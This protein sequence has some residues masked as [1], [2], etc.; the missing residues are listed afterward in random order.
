MKKNSKEKTARIYSEALYEAAENASKFDAVK[1]DAEFLAD[2]CV[3]NKDLIKQSSSPLLSDV[4]QREIWQQVAAKAKFNEITTKCLDVLIENHRIDILQEV[5]NDFVHLY[6]QRK[7]IA[8]V[9]VETVKNLTAKQDEMLRKVLQKKLE[10]DVVIEYVINP[11]LLGGLRI[12]S[13]S[14]MFDGS[15][16]Y[17]LNC[18]ENIMKGN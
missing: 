18:L 1:K 11:A 9:R 6:N 14:K 12:Q 15:L 3:Q 17:K 8:E 13:G 4:Q 7:G 5:M 2:L 10:S 16:S